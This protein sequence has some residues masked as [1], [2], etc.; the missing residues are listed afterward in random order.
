VGDEEEIRT[1]TKR[2]KRKEKGMGDKMRLNRKERKERE[3][4][5]P[6]DAV[7]NQSSPPKKNKRHTRPKKKKTIDAMK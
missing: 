5:A 1:G 4:V 7:R 6:Q 2:G 3:R